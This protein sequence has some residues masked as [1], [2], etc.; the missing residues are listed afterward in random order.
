MPIPLKWS[1][2]QTV[3]GS[4]FNTVRLNRGPDYLIFKEGTLFYAFAQRS[5]LTDASG[6]D[7]S[8]LLTN[9]MAATGHGCIYIKDL[10]NTAFTGSYDPYFTLIFEHSGSITAY[11]N[12]YLSGS[13][14]ITGSFS[15]IGGDTSLSGSLLV[16]NTTIT[17]SL[18]VNSVTGSLYVT[19]S[20]LLSGSSEF[21]QTTGVL[22]GGTWY[23][24]EE[25]AS[26]II[27]SGSSQY[28]VKNGSTGKIDYS[29]SDACTIIQAAISALTSGGKIFVKRG[30]YGNDGEY[31]AL[32]N[33]IHLY[34]EGSTFEPFGSYSIV[35]P[36]YM[37][38]TRFKFR[39]SMSNVIGAGVHNIGI[40]PDAFRAGEAA[41]AGYSIH[42]CIFERV[43]IAG[44][45]TGIE[46]STLDEVNS[47]S[48]LN[49]IL[50]PII[51][52]AVDGIKLTK[53]GAG[54]KAEVTQ[55]IGGGIYGKSIGEPTA[56]G[57][58]ITDGDFTTIMGTILVNCTTGIQISDSYNQVI[59]P[60]FESVVTGI[61]LDQ[62][63][64]ANQFISLIGMGRGGVVTNWI[65]DHGTIYNELGIYLK[66]MG[67]VLATKDTQLLYENSGTATISAPSGSLAHGLVSA[68][69]IV[70][71][72]VSGS[73]PAQVS[74]TSSG[75]AG[76]WV[77]HTAGGDLPI[78]WKAEV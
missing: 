31:I 19:G 28:Y 60:H 23:G 9:A 29:G 43:S 65:N 72:T 36:P 38:P 30:V 32:K 74:W 46:I 50:Y 45:A 2:G 40:V 4:D 26:Y 55:I 21:T 11:G 69:T 34:G 37:P 42:Y 20:L 57:I 18:G 1:V 62:T 67:K 39:V 49:Q 77:Y 33:H 44:F 64:E 58:N 14:S 13:E 47:Y 22:K 27:F 52:N 25:T 71:L 70:N 17:G 15:V 53:N 63:V 10:D 5:D 3:S 73:I 6:S 56:R 12:I 76:I 68:P 16:G 51:F 61:L 59:S 8:A 7:V 48:S 35:T 78:S 24:G 41:I 75:S 54:Y 66:N